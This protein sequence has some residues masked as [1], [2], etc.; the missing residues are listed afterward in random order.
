LLRAIGDA[1]AQDRLI[2]FVL[3]GNRA[4][5]QRLERGTTAWASI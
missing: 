1:A 3:Q 2:E 4:H 5:K